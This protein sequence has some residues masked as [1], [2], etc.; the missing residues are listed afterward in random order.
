[1]TTIR[2]HVATALTLISS[3]ALPGCALD[4]EPPP[5]TE[6]LGEVRQAATSKDPVAADVAY[7]AKKKMFLVVWDEGTPGSSDVMGSLVR[8]NGTT[9]RGPFAISTATGSQSL[10][11]VASDGTSFFVVW[12]DGRNNGDDVYG[13]RVLATGQV[14]HPSGVVITQG[15]SFAT[16][17]DIGYSN[18]NYLAVWSDDRAADFDIYGTRVDTSGNVLDPSGVLI[19]GTAGSEAYPA[20]EGNDVK[21]LVG[22]SSFAPGSSSWDIEGRIVKLTPT[23]SS[24]ALITIGTS[25]EHEFKIAFGSDGD[26]FCAAWQNGPLSDAEINVAPVWEW[27]GVGGVTA[28]TPPTG[29]TAIRP[30][31]AHVRNRYVA[32]WNQLPQS[33]TQNGRL[34]GQSLAA[35]DPVGA[36]FLIQK[37]RS[38]DRGLEVA[39]DATNAMTVWADINPSGQH[40]TVCGDIR[41]E[42]GTS[43]FPEFPIRP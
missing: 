23:L 16:A 1:M 4:S 36:P 39:S 18:G 17:P 37:L 21:F 8:P 42:T 15:S 2:A 29:Q 22:W 14:S 32:T 13:T 38:Q 10:P 43:V 9:F 30:S 25:P 3:V 40:C 11:R 31:V 20:V 28:V 12:Q 33:G 6:E 5:E 24:G 41:T 27:G 7:A 35:C 19:S 34:Y 26:N